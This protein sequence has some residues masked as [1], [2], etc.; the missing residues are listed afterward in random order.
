MKYYY[1]L[2]LFF[3]CLPAAVM[4]QGMVTDI[5]IVAVQK[6]KDLA[7]HTS[8]Y[9]GGGDEDLDFRKGRG[10]GYVFALFKNSADVKDTAN[11][12]T[13][14]SVCTR[15]AYGQQFKSGDKTYVPAS[16]FQAQNHY[17]KLYRGGLNG[18]DYSIYGGK[19]TEQP[20]VYVSHTGCTDFS[21][22]VLKKAYVKTSKPSGKASDEYSGGH[23]GGK[24]YFVFEW[25]THENRYKTKDINWHTHYCDK[26]NCKLSKEEHHTFDQLY[27]FDM[28]K[29]F[30]ASDPL[31]DTRHYKKCNECGQVVTQEHQFST[32][33]ADWGEHNKRCMTCDYVIRANHVNF[34]KEQ[35]PVDDYYH[36]I[37]C[38]CGFLKKL[39][40][41]YGDERRKRF[42]D[43]ERTTLEYTCKQ[44]YH[45]ALIDQP[46]EGHLYNAY[47]ICQRP[48]CAHPYERP[49]AERRS[50]GDSTFVVRTFGHLYWVADFVNNSH[51][52]THIRLAE[53]LIA[54]S[55]MK[56][57][58][59]PIG[60]T[61]ST[62]FEGTFDGGGHAISMLKT[63][64][65]I[66]GNNCRGFFGVVGKNAEV[67]N[68]TLAQ[69]DIQGWDYIGAVAG[70]NKGT[71]SGCN[72]VFSS[73]SSIG[74]GKNLGGICGVNKGTV[75]NCTT[76]GSVWVGGVRD[77]AGGI[78]GTN[79]G[80]T[81][82]GNTTAAICG[83][84]SDAV[85]PEAA[86]TA[87]KTDN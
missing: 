31:C 33:S 84:G 10:G 86:A 25:H 70:I 74:S 22:K 40:H 35:I 82:S 65:P 83:S 46:G 3:L 69:C 20:H 15:D 17:D 30:D 68:M 21:Q 53:D 38:N 54:D 1:T 56:R 57:P 45:R 60:A 85:L 62:A 49:A 44:C 37:Y 80:G 4:A 32:Y 13:S 41:I 81:L 16:F 47:G 36:M 67:K 6:F 76:T 72:V 24:R 50:D 59:R 5:K 75:T 48:G 73:V 51:P 64:E 19:Y 79:E 34:G 26:E 18:R 58:W 28:W 2:L 39:P 61:D 66:A 42:S 11:Y 71:I 77:Y 52:K 43:C 27:G 29:Q 7:D 8:G 9:S 23:A 87:V 12:I 14:V 55:L 78:C 63:E